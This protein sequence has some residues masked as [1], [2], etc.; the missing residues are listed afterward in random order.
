MGYYFRSR[1]K[2]KKRWER[3]RHEVMEAFNYRCAMCG[4]VI[5]LR[6]ADI[7]HVKPL[8]KMRLDEDAY[9]KSN[10]QPLCRSRCHYEKTVRE[11]AEID[12][13][14]KDPD[15]LAWIA[16]VEELI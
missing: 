12:R 15:K 8:K 7:D 4:R 11:N 2:D 3:I 16:V 9:D 10:L 6:T 5:S 13:M 1:I 14:T